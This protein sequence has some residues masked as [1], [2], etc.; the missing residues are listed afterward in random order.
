MGSIGLY[1]LGIKKAGRVTSVG[2]IIVKNHAR[3]AILE[4]NLENSDL[5][6]H[7]RINWSVGDGMYSDRG[8]IR[9]YILSILFQ[10]TYDTE[11][12]IYIQRINLLI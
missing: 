10:S 6:D 2:T 5:L 3:R 7:A 8:C 12:V 1:P 11:T 9:Y 4:K